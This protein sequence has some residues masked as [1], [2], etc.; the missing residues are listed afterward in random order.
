MDGIYYP[1]SEI[2]SCIYYPLTI[3]GNVS[4]IS[5][6]VVGL[7]LYINGSSNIINPHIRNTMK[8]ELKNNGKSL[9]ELNHNFSARELDL[10]KIKVKSNN[11]GNVSSVIISGL[12]D[13][14]TIYID[15][16]G[17]R[18]RFNSICIKDAEINSL[19]EISSSCN[20]SSE[21][22]VNSIPYNSNGYTANYIDT[23]NSSVVVTGLMHSGVVQQC[24]ENWQC[25][26]WT[27]CSN[28]M[29]NRN[30]TDTNNCGSVNTKPNIIQACSSDTSLSSG[31]TTHTYNNAG[32]LNSSTSKNNTGVTNLSGQNIGSVGSSFS[33]SSTSLS[34]PI[35]SSGDKSIL[36]SDRTFIYYMLVGA[37]VIA[38]LII[39][40][41]ILFIYRKRK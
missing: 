41:I 36:S 24:T 2:I 37:L 19:S 17:D 32:S 25:F 10:S 12:N 1:S 15:L 14:K 38:I 20:G 5:T 4:N 11:T 6:N 3:I 22:Y 28:D 29:Q 8:V 26:S 27:D 39:L 33:D 18:S 9:L 7:S 13:T 21:F 16:I 23:S 34:S 40:M 35:N 30:C 31:S